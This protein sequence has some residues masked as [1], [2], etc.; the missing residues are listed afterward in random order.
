MIESRESFCLGSC[1]SVRPFV[2]WVIAARPLCRCAGCT[3]AAFHPCEQ[4][5][6][7][8]TDFAPHFQ[9]RQRIAPSRAPHG[10]GAGGNVEDR[11]SGLVV[12]QISARRDQVL[13][14]LGCHGSHPLN[15]AGVRDGCEL[16]GKAC[17]RNS[18]RVSPLR[19]SSSRVPGVA[20]F[21]YVAH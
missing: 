9:E 17:R 5:G 1:R 4:V 6:T 11:G 7:A 21:G 12:E 10:Q 18:E 20:G 2:F 14:V 8:V 13:Q 19:A 16:W 3:G 15:P